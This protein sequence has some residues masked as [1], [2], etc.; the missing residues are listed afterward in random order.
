[1]GEKMK[2]LV[3]FGIVS[4]ALGFIFVSA[5]TAN[6]QNRREARREYREEVRDA[7]REYREDLWEGKNPRK[8]RREYRREVR[9]AR[10][11]YRRDV[12]RDRRGWYYFNN[13]R[14]IYRPYSQWRY[15]NGWF[16]RVY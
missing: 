14:R 7:R 13:G 15:R 11:E 12:R 8:A 10:R 9:E 4:A 3:K 6:A 16:Y 5:D 2:N 1:M